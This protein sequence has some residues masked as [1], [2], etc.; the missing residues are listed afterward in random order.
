MTGLSKRLEVLEYNLQGFDGS[1][2]PV[3]PLYPVQEQGAP[4]YSLSSEHITPH[5]HPHPHPHLRTN[6]RSGLRPEIKRKIIRI[7]RQV[8]KDSRHILVARKLAEESISKKKVTDPSMSLDARL[9]KLEVLCS[10]LDASRPFGPEKKQGAAPEHASVD[11]DDDSD[12]KREEFVHLSQNVDG[13][14]TYMANLNDHVKQNMNAVSD[15]TR[16]LDN[17]TKSMENAH[18][19]IE[20]VETGDGSSLHVLQQCGVLRQCTG[21]T[22]HNR[23]GARGGNT[24]WEM[25]K[26]HIATV[27]LVRKVSN[28]VSAIEE[29]LPTKIDLAGLLKLVV[30]KC[31][32][33]FLP[34]PQQLDIS[35]DHCPCPLPKDQLTKDKTTTSLLELL[36]ANERL[37][38]LRTDFDNLPDAEIHR[39]NQ[40]Q[41]QAHIRD[42]DRL[43]PLPAERRYGDA[44]PL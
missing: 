2:Y 35:I 23:N 25:D 33:F 29:V 13:I 7:L 32:I 43:K 17:V 5:P 18:K 1:G 26:S 38:S 41:A 4:R 3:I 27:A 20:R 42:G 28:L 24:T 9:C 30:C 22:S 12:V 11:S 10:N 16:K 15:V 19:K 40:N 8:N 14:H 44:E 36:D 6:L 39:S 34:G 31:F 37:E 21:C